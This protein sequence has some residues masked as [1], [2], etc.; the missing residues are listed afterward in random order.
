VGI[1]L[2]STRAIDDAMLIAQQMMHP[3]E[4]AWLRRQR[5][6][7]ATS[8]AFLRLWVR[9]EAVVKAST[10]GLSMRLDSW[11]VLPDVAQP[12]TVV[13]A[14]GQAWQLHDGQL[15]ATHVY[16][17]ACAPGM[18][19]RGPHVLTSVWLAQCFDVCER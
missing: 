13:D 3:A 9:K 8:A 17:V 5:G 6:P 11:H 15:D 4:L 18:R 7:A 16:A 1:D 10:E 2:E 12:T 19:V 14:R